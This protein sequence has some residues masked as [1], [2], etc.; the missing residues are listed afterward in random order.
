MR[1]WSP[2]TCSIRFRPFAKERRQNIRK[3][4]KRHTQRT[5]CAGVC[6]AD[7]AIKTFTDRGVA[8]LVK[9][10]LLLYRV[11]G[12]K[13]IEMEQIKNFENSMEALAVSFAKGNELPSLRDR[14]EAEMSDRPWLLY[15]F[16]LSKWRG[17]G[18]KLPARTE[19]TTTQSREE[20]M[21]RSLRQY[22]K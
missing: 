9:S 1:R 17:S 21:K 14:L 16:G 11:A 10:I 22:Q 4:R 20:A 3:R 15:F 8:K 19:R 7:A 5:F 13:S 2:V 6:S 12:R 18:E